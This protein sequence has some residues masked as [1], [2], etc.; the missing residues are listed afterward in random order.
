[1]AARKKAAAKGRA[2]VVGGATVALG[3]KEQASLL[4]KY[5]SRVSGRTA[6]KEMAQGLPWIST[7]GQTFK[8]GDKALGN[9]IEVVILDWFYEHRLY[10]GQFDA[11]KPRGAAC[12]AIGRDELELAA[13]AAIAKA[14]TCATCTLNAFGSDPR[15]GKGK[16][17][18]NQVRLVLLDAQLIRDGSAPEALI[19]HLVTVPVTSTKNWQRYI[20]ALKTQ[21]GEWA[22]VPAISVIV[23]DKHPTNQT[24]MSFRWTGEALPEATAEALIALARDREAELAAP[25]SV[26]VGGEEAV[27]PAK[28]RRAS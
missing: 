20:K 11:K 3:T 23:L 12:Y 28:R 13:P 27:K 5:R 22:P 21:F 2:L 25:P 6:S 8:V 24:E 7:K 14:P 17:C 4:E 1:M 9:E 19:P 10:V 26:E 15:G 18:K 16:A